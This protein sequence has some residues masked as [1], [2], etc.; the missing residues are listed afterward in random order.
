MARTMTRGT[1]SLCGIAFGKRAMLRHVAACQEK[2]PGSVSSQRRSA[3]PMLQVLVDT[4]YAPWYWIYLGMPADATLRDLDDFL[5]ATWLECCGHLSAFTIG[6]VTYSM[7]TDGPWGN[8]MDDRDMD[9]AVGNVLKVGAVF[10]HEYDFGST[11]ELRLKVVRERHGQPDGAL[12]QLLARNEPPD[13]GCSE[14]DQPASQVCTECP[15]EDGGPVCRSCASRHR[16][17]A[18]LPLVNSPRT[19]VCGYTG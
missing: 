1:C 11:T 12:V 13:I 15:Y 16:R 18:R 19:G 10:R 4:R 2:R 3:V 8:P 14:C 9:V 6:E 17:H 7:A 5:R